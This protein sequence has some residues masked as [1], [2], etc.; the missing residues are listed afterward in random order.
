MQKHFKICM[1]NTVRHLSKVLL[2]ITRIL[3]VSY[4]LTALYSFLCLITGWSLA[5]KDAG[6]YF[7]I[8][9]P[10]TETPFLIGD[11]NIPYILFYFMLPL[12]LYGIF[13]WLAGNVFSVF[14]QDRLFTWNGVK[15][16]KWFYSTNLFVPPV[17]ILLTSLFSEVDES[18]ILVVL[19]LFL[20]VFAFFLAAIFKQG[21]NLQNE[22]D[23]II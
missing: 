17:L 8:L 10:F 11:N 14:T 7:L 5:F 2:V 22:Q 21:L 1:M 4:G 9:Y 15:Q 23:L 19:H 20:G 6:K 13:F 16:L 3:A 18:I 12:S